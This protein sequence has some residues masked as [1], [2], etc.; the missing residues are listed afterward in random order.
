MGP[1]QLMLN[2]KD[3]AAA[4]PVLKAA[5]QIEPNSAAL[6][7]ALMMHYARSGDHDDASIELQRLYRLAP[8]SIAVKTLLQ[9]RR[10]P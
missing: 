9:Q 3:N 8:N 7:F 10:D 4:I 5:Q 1:A 2:F 6:T